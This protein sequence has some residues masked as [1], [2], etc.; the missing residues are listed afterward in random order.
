LRGVDVSDND[1]GKGFS[2]S[3]LELVNSSLPCNKSK[4]NPKRKRK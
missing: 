2:S 1:V 4:F 3:V